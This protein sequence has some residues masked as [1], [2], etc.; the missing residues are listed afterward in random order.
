[1]VVGEIEEARAFTDSDGNNRALLEFTASTVK[2]M[3]GK[4]N[5]GDDATVN[6]DAGNGKD[7]DIPF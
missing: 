3:D 4:G 7:E 1:M 6:A 2:F 5:I